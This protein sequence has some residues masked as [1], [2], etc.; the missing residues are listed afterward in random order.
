M[1]EAGRLE[2]TEEAEV[3]GKYA[4]ELYMTIIPESNDNNPDQNPETSNGINNSS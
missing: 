4:E 1:K 2:E 3:M